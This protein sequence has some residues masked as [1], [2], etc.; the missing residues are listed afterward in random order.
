MNIGSG[1]Q[2][3][4]EL[5]ST[6]LIGRHTGIYDYLRLEKIDIPLSSLYFTGCTS[7]LV[8]KYNFTGTQAGP[9]CN[10]VLTISEPGRY[11][12]WL[13][14]DKIHRPF[15]YHEDPASSKLT[16]VEGTT[17]SPVFFEVH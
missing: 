11:M 1:D 2:L 7:L 4:R 12:L 10:S 6:P 3:I 16:R 8:P 15:F 9:L 14:F 5:I 17:G 13:S